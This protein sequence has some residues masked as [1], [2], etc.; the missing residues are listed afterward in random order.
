M[1]AW[2]KSVSMIAGA[3]LAINVAMIAVGMGPNLL[4]VAAL[5]GLIGVA[6]WTVAELVDATPPTAPIDATTQLAP[7]SRGERRVTRLRTGL[8]SAGPDGPVF[9]R[10]HES[11]VEVIDDQLRV[12]HQIDPASDPEAARAVLG[13]EL[14]AFVHDG[15]TATR[16][17]ARPR[18]LDHILTLIE[19]L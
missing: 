11:L 6:G 15:A 8:A 16:E 9:E 17:L 10:L 12:V 2:A 14:H 1:R 18:R 4:V 7:P 13:E 5:V 19:Q 3:A